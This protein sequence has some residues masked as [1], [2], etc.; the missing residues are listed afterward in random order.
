[1]R[2]EKTIS[3]SGFVDPWISPGPTRTADQ[4]CFSGRIQFFT[5]LSQPINSVVHFST[6]ALYKFVRRNFC[7]ANLISLHFFNS[8]L[9]Q[10]LFAVEFTIIENHIQESGVIVQNCSGASAQH[11]AVASTPIY[12]CLLYTSPS[13]RD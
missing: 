7:F 3:I 6:N 10:N 12:S 13:P 9:R 8:N 1:M 2:N 11:R 4:Y 5:P